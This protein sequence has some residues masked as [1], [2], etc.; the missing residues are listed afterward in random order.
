MDVIVIADSGSV[1]VSGTNKLKLM[2]DGHVATIQAIENFLDNNGRVIDPVIGDGVSSWA[3][4]LKLNGI[5][6]IAIYSN[7]DLMLLNQ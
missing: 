1:S 4:S 7:K 6:Y 5:F 2:V 3:S